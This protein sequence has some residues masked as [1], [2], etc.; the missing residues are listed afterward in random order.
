MRPA[1]VAIPMNLDGS[2]AADS[3]KGPRAKLPRRPTHHTPFPLRRALASLA[4]A[5]Q[6]VR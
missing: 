3:A 4:A 6:M 1:S 2:D 5:A